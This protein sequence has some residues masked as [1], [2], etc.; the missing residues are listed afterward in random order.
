[1]SSIVLDRKRQERDRWLALGLLLLALLLGYL[2]LLHTWW[3][4]PMLDA[5]SRI[6]TLQQR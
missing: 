1:M 2:V 5:Q 6:E 3:T 4:A